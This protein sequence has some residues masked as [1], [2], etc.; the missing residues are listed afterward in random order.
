MRSWDRMVI[1]MPFSRAIFLY[2]DPI[3]VSRDDDVE[4]SRLRVERSLDALAE[5][6][7]R[8][9]DPLWSRQP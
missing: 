4:E 9:F 3:S 6:A 8:D 2:G 5:Q 7:E 1:P